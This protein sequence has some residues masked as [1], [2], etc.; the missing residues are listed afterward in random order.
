MNFMYEY[1]DQLDRFV[2]STLLTGTNIHAIPRNINNTLNVWT[3]SLS[4]SLV[5]EKHLKKAHNVSC[6]TALQFF[7][8]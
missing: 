4:I 5:G 3:N 7:F 8:S 1:G 6:E 2:S